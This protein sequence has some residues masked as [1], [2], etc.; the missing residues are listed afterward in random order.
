MTEAVTTSDAAVVAAALPA[1]TLAAEGEGMPF[2][3]DVAHDYIDSMLTAF[4]YLLGDA[5]NRATDPK[6]TAALTYMLKSLLR[7][8]LIA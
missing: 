4:L 1:I 7:V 3:F 6:D 2:D 5:L 8:A